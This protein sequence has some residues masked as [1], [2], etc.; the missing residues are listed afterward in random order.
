MWKKHFTVA[1]CY[2]TWHADVHVLG[3]ALHSSQWLHSTVPGN[4]RWKNPQHWKI[5]ECRPTMRWADVFCG[6]VVCVCLTHKTAFRPSRSRFFFTFLATFVFLSLLLW[7]CDSFLLELMM[8]S[9]A[10]IAKCASRMEL[11]SEWVEFNCAQPDTFS[12]IL[13]VVLKASHFDWYWQK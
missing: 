6:Y 12:V 9:I 10:Y 11:M 8:R 5:S 4:G 7:N 2:C 3:A 13:Q 1:V